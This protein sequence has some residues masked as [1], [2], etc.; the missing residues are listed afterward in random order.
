M[1]WKPDTYHS[2]ASKT[3]R[4]SQVKNG[5]QKSMTTQE[6]SEWNSREK[7]TSADKTESERERFVCVSLGDVF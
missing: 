5:E 7:K 6:T 2:S 3:K 4:G 1:F